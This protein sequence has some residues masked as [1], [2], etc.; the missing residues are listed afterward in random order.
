MA[1]NPPGRVH[2]FAQTFVIDGSIDR[3]N[4]TVP[5]YIRARQIIIDYAVDPYIEVVHED[6]SELKLNFT[7]AVIFGPPSDL[8]F[9]VGQLCA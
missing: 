8:T 9:Q 2:V 7:E 6:D 3:S 4:S 5:L 1:A